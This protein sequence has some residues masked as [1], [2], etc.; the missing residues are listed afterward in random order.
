MKYRLLTAASR[1]KLVYIKLLM[2]GTMNVKPCSVVGDYQSVGESTGFST[3]KE[4]A[5]S[6]AETSFLQT[7]TSARTLE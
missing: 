4:K 5:E 1:W 6:P 2:H 7:L 3:L